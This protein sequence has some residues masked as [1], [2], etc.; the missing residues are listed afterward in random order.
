MHLI[1]TGLCSW[2]KPGHG[3]NRIETCDLGV[4]VDH[5]LCTFDFVVFN[6]ILGS[7]ST[8]FIFLKIALNKARP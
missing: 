1:P 2:E 8:C 6:V 5:I 3:A 4:L 7:F